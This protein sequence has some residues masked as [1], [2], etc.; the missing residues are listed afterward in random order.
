[1]LMMTLKIVPC[2]SKYAQLSINDDTEK[3]SFIFTLEVQSSNLFM[4]RLTLS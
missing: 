2:F 3:V 1:M 4:V